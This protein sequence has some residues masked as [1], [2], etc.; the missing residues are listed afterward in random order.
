M[1][2]INGRRRGGSNADDENDHPRVL[3]LAGHTEVANAIPTQT[4]KAR[5]LQRLSN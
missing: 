5:A 4:G 1:G 3:N 2:R